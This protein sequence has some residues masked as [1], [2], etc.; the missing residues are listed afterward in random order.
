MEASEALQKCKGM[1][2]TK[3][4][5]SINIHDILKKKLPKKA[6]FVDPSEPLVNS[7]L[8]NPEGL[9][10]GSFICCR[11]WSFWS[12]SPSLSSFRGKKASPRKIP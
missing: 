1:I 12:M 11:S 10:N 9:D 2:L 4:G 8:P 3:E 7:Y 5:I 6:L